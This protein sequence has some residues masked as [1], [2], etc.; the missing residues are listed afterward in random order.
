[1]RFLIKPVSVVN[2]FVG[3]EPQCNRCNNQ[4]AVRCP[5]Q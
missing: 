3:Y 5:L 1:M 2:N 4:C